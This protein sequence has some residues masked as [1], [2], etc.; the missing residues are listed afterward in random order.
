MNDN[1]MHRANECG[2]FKPKPFVTKGT[3]EIQT[4]G[5]AILKTSP[6]VKALDS[7]ASDFLD[8]LKM[9]SGF[10]NFLSSLP[11]T[12]AI[13]GAVATSLV[14]AGVLYTITTSQGKMP[15]DLTKASQCEQMPLHLSPNLLLCRCV[16]FF[17]SLH[18]GYSHAFGHTFS[19]FRLLPHFHSSIIFV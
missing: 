1:G 4:V 15:L 9:P 13:G 8:F 2:L 6:R 18:S 16:M 5:D 14:L 3:I 7:L 11:K 19:C 17:H 12:K 10:V